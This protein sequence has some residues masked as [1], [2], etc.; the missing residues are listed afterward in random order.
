MQLSLLLEG[1]KVLLGTRNSPLYLPVSKTDTAAAG[2]RR[3]HRTAQLC[4]RNLTLISPG[5][6]GRSVGEV[7]LRTKATDLLYGIFIYIHYIIIK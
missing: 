3:A 4:P 1:Y 7:R 5:S 6:G 2:I